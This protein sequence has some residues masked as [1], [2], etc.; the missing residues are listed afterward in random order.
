MSH[1]R[2][3]VEAVDVRRPPAPVHPNASRFHDL[4]ALSTRDGF[5]RAPERVSLADLH[6]DERDQIP[7]PRDHI[8]LHTSHPEPVRHD[9]PAAALEV[10]HR[11]FFTGEAALMAFVG[12]LLWV[13]ANPAVHGGKLAHHHPTR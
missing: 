12:P 10:A 4:A 5:E 1:Q 7:T 3:T 6:L 13:A 8:D 11:S 2:D 9:V